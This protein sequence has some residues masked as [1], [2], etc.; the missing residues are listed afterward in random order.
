M[1]SIYQLRDGVSHLQGDYV[2]ILLPFLGT[3]LVKIVSEFLV[4]SFCYHGFRICEILSFAFWAPGL[5]GFRVDVQL[6]I[7]RSTTP[8]R[9]D[10]E[11]AI[12]RGEHSRYLAFGWLRLQVVQ[13]YVRLGRWPP[14][15]IEC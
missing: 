3:G 11:A 15:R 6:E 10:L 9:R 7:E 2:Y 8:A 13:F 1:H 12:E 14:A 5:L 4:V